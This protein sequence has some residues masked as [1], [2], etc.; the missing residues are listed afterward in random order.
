MSSQL[1][2]EAAARYALLA[3]LTVAGLAVLVACGPA[4]PEDSTGT[5]KEAA[6]A[7]VTAAMEGAPTRQAGDAGE[8]P[9]LATPESPAE[10]TYQVAQE[11][12]EATAGIVDTG[13][14]VGQQQ[15]LATFTPAPDAPK[16]N[17]RLL[18]VRTGRFY[19]VKAN[20]EELEPLKLE[21]E[22]PAVWSPPDDPGR[23]WSSPDGERVAFLAGPDAAMWV[24]RVDGRDNHP[25]SEN[26]MPSHEH[27]VATADGQEQTVRLLPGS[28]YTLV[29][30]PGR[31]QPFAV[32][33]DD[34]SRHVRGEG[35]IRVVHAAAMFADRSLVARLNG[36]QLGSE[37]AYGGSTGDQRTY[38]GPMQQLEIQDDKQR[39]LARLPD[40]EL[41]DR[42][43]L[44]VFLYGDEELLGARA[45]Y[46]PGTRPPSGNSRLR[47][48][49]SGRR[50]LSVT[51]DGSIAAAQDLAPGEVGG[52]AAVPSVADEGQVADLQQIVY[53]LRSREEPV[54]WSPD[55][56]KLAFLG[57]GDGDADLYVTDVAGPARRVTTSD[58]QEANPVWS[59]DS[60]YMAW[61]EMDP[62]FQ[63]HD[64]AYWRDG[65]EASLVNLTPIRSAASWA[66]TA[67]IAF[68]SGVEWMAD[69]RLA[70]Y[71]R[72]ARVSAGIWTVDVD[73]GEIEQVYAEGV[74]NPSW[75]AE[76]GAWVFVHQDDVGEIYVLRPGSE[77][78][79]VVESGGHYPL[80]SP[81]GRRLSYVEGEPT[82]PDGWQIH[83]MDADGSN[84]EQLTER[85]PVL[86]EEP[87][88]PG[89]NAKRFWLGGGRQ[90][91]FTRAG[92]DYGKAEEAGPMRPVEA[93][94]DIENLWVVPSDGSADSWRATDLT[95]VFYLSGVSE[96]PDGSALGIVAFSYRD[97]S[98]QLWAVAA[99]HG[100]PIHIDG[101][102]R[103]FTWL[104]D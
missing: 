49:N 16:L 45:G 25:V 66:E 70:L 81:D 99:D 102:V 54:A 37:I 97:R 17:G 60:R 78:R 1:K 94:D 100:K 96:S 90:L 59:P 33:V 69:N 72:S 8:L 95:R 4:T 68:P 85:L 71:P 35:R 58:R 80:W 87:P 41:L 74:D 12:A 42:E 9:G 55:G 98:Q 31:D 34:N 2:R 48:F 73:T 23:A 89:A 64:I 15:P 44:T 101:P 104:P 11:A 18:Y 82:S 51:V 77:V 61:V 76:A 67:P 103:W 3:F 21:H 19:T 6:L 14:L 28:D 26:N 79:R 88:V 22:M 52:Y 46:E 10:A 83:V 47:V 62:R 43:L 29:L 91:G 86:Q 93:G 20:G 38:S 24:M 36:N 13:R 32:L 75:S 7:K 53:G 39:E 84:D 30:T 57:A 50:P 5:D 27:M 65:Q 63:G 56:D 92:T 40:F